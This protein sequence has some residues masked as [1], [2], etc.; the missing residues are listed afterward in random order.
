MA[1]TLATARSGNLKTV[2]PVIA[3]DFEAIK[4]G[5]TKLVKL[6]KEESTSRSSDVTRHIKKS[7][8]K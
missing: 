1:T 4:I 5:F 3:K 6:K 8:L 2:L 7:F